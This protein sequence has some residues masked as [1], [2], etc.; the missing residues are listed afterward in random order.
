MKRLAL[1]LLLLTSYICSY[2][3]DYNELPPEPKTIDKR[4]IKPLAWESYDIN[5]TLELL[6]G[7]NRLYEKSEDIHI[8]IPT[9]TQD[10]VFKYASRGNVS[11]STDKKVRSIAILQQKDKERSLA[12]LYYPYGNTVNITLPLKIIHASLNAL[13]EGLKVT[14]VIETVNDRLYMYEYPL[15]YSGHCDQG[16]DM[17]EYL[18]DLNE[19]LDKNVLR[20]KYSIDE[21]GTGTLKFKMLHP[22]VSYREAEKKMIKANF[23]SHINA[24]V[25]NK[26]LF[27]LYTSGYIRT[28]PVFIMEFPNMKRG[29]SIDFSYSTINGEVIS[30]EVKPLTNILTKSPSGT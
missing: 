27:D 9:N 15:Y 25:K 22:M 6:Y 16:Y 20:T 7:K 11:I 2:E 10:A 24:S 17:R 26:K 4:S 30:K 14:I 5:Q 3:F 19:Y 23:I 29:E 1:I 8:K 18:D 21:N 13:K 28:K 12:A